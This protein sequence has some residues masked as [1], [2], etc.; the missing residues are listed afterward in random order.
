[1]GYT[2]D[3]GSPQDIVY[4]CGTGNKVSLGM[5][6]LDNGFRVPVGMGNVGESEGK[7]VECSGPG[8]LYISEVLVIF[9]WRHLHLR[10]VSVWGSYFVW[11]GHMLRGCLGL[12]V[13]VYGQLCVPCDMSMFCGLLLMSVG[14]CLWYCRRG[15]G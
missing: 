14:S 12:M 8:M 4:L 3:C 11:L 2:R 9:S 15:L 10:G 5:Q 7:M 6:V 13:T 1:M